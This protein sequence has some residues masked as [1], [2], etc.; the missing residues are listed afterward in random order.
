M[1]K[2]VLRYGAYAGVA[3]FVFFVLTWLVIDITRVE[4]KL[5]GAIGYVAIIC[6]MIFVY[7]GIRYYRDRV[8]D[9]NL[10]FMQALKV[11][12]LIVIIPTI[13][14]AI[15]E[16]VYV[17][18]IEPK[19]YENISLYDIEQYRK[20]LSAAAF[21]VKLKEIKQQVALYNNPLYNFAGMILTIGALGTIVT[22][23]SALLLYRRPGNTNSP[24]QVNLIS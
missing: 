15:I 16:T 9:G 17:L 21:A 5:Q 8:N 10:T 3:E 12:L 1:K 24:E 19:F 11:G 20:T 2:V 14:F 22:V 7:F 13:S 6:P 23:A 18:Y 4:H